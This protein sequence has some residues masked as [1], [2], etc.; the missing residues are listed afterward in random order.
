MV[1]AAPAP[2]KYGATGRRKESVARVLLRPGKGTFMVNGK[3]IS[4]YLCR[5]T[6]VSHAREPLFA[7]EL[8][9]ALDVVASTSGGGTAGQAG[10]IRLALSRALEK[11]RPETHKLLRR[12]GFLTR[13]SRAVER[14]KYGRPKARK[15]F[16]YSKR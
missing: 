4:D 1:T 6:L 15:R 14:K 5:E 10:A 11:F 8:E 12:N 7:T 3:K 2:V 16:Q 9:T 13:D